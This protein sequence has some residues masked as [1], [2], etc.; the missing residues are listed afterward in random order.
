M[1]DGLDRIERS[2][3]KRN[4]EHPPLHLWHPPLS[5]AIDI[6]IAADGR[7]FHEGGEIRRDALVRLF[8]S[9]LRCE[10]DG[11][12]YLVTPVEKWRIVV[13]KHPL[14]VVRVDGTG[15][16]RNERLIATLNT[17]SEIVIGAD[18]P[19]SLDPELQV[20]VLE[21]SNGLT[22]LFNRNAW[23]HLVDLADQNHCVTS[24]GMVFRLAP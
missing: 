17:G 1:T 2:I 4:F 11:E 5:G 3:S 7:W 14:M 20:P 6:R 9:I 23:Y 12:Y 16:G 18:H 21:A 13:E 8:A 22:A 15:V 19:L 24:D 10:E